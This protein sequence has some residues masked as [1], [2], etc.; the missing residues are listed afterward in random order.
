MEGEMTPAERPLSDVPYGSRIGCSCKRC[1]VCCPEHR[2]RFL[3][4]V[5]V[6]PGRKSTTQIAALEELEAEFPIYGIKILSGLLPDRASRAARRWAALFWSSPGGAIC[7]SCFTRRSIRG[8]LFARPLAFEVIEAAPDLRFCLAH[9]IA[10][11]RGYL[12]RAA[13]MGNVWVDTAAMKI[14]VAVAASGSPVMA[15][16]SDRFDA[17]YCDYRRVFAALAEAYPEMILW[18]TDSPCYSYV[19]RRKQGE[20]A[21]RGVPPRSP[22]RGRKSRPGRAAGGLA[23]E[24][25]QCEHGEVLV[26]GV[27]RVTAAHRDFFQIPSYS[28]RR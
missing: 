16:G 20:D 27:P 19:A 1:S 23:G 25:E 6:D 3:P 8:R 26:W 4:F 13:A 11:H 18:G 10:F 17:D 5:S 28:S 7:R 24:G 21:F 14:Q 22:L 15:A 12:D 2:R 9:C